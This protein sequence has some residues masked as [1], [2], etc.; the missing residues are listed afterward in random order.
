MLG[1]VHRKKYGHPVH[2]GGRFLLVGG[3]VLPTRALGQ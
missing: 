2:Q 1:A 3:M